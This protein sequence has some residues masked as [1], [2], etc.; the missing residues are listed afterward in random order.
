MLVNRLSI[1]EKNEERDPPHTVLAWSQWVAIRV[2][3]CNRDVSL[4]SNRMQNWGDH[5]AWAAP[6][7]PEVDQNPL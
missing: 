5:L 1:V 2:D 7:C 6:W 4:L 3:L